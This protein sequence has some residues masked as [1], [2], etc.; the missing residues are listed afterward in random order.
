MYARAL[1]KFELSNR[2]HIRYERGDVF[3]II[4]IYQNRESTPTPQ[5][6]AYNTTLI[7]QFS[8]ISKDIRRYGGLFVDL[9][10][11]KNI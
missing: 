5:T 6:Y 10:I 7:S 3:S 8:I 9:T 11:L 2:R 4:K 1:F